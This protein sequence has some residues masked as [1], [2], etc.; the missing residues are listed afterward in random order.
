MT[1]QTYIETL[2][3]KPPHIR[4]RYSFLASLGITLV[5][6]AFWLGSFSSFG[7]TSQSAVAQAAHKAASPGASL[8]A[9]VGSLFTDIKDIIFGPKKMTF[10]TVEVKPGKK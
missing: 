5:I 3:A 7:K 6:F 4:K 2:R 10:S 1:V 8:V 9:S